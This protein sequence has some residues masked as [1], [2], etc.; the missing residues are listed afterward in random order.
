MA[1]RA[2]VWAG[3]G[4]WHWW[5]NGWRPSVLYSSRS[6]PVPWPWPSRRQSAQQRPRS[7]ARASVRSCRR[8]ATVRSAA[9]SG[10]RPWFRG[11]PRSSGRN[12]TGQPLSVWRP[13]P[14]NSRA[15]SSRPCSASVSTACAKSGEQP[16]RKNA[17]GAV[18]GRRCLA[19]RSARSSSG[20]SFHRPLPKPA[21]R[22]RPKYSARCR[23]S[24]SKAARLRRA[25]RQRMCSAWP[26]R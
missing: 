20:A 22:R 18:N 16:S 24:A 3:T 15:R 7:G 1:W 2:Q 5:T 12:G 11:S 4:S 26:T 25:R 6:S 10:L 19:A 14:T 21:Q 8:Q 13:T 17:R 9:W 23:P